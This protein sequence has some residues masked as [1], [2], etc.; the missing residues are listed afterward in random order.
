MKCLICGFDVENSHICPNC[1]QN[2]Y[3]FNKI[4]NI[5]ARLYNDALEKAQ[6]NDFSNAIILIQKSL[7]FNK[8]NTEARNLL[9]L[10]YYQIG[11]LGDAV[12]QWILSSNINTKEDNKAFYYL[13]IFN[14]NIRNFEKLDDAVRLYNQAIKYL[15]NKNDDLAIIRIK[16]ALD[17]NPNF[18]DAIN[19]L[20]FCYILQRKYKQ[21]LKMFQKVLTLDI[22]NKTAINYIDEIQ[23]KK[24]NKKNEIL[25]EQYNYNGMIKTIDEENKEETAQNKTRK[26]VIVSFIIGVIVCGITMYYLFIPGYM[27]KNNKQIEDLTNKIN[28]IKEDTEKIVSEKDGIITSLQQENENTKNQ[29]QSYINIQNNYKKIDEA[30]E[31]YKQGK[32][33]DAKTVIDSVLTDG[34]DETMLKKYN[35]AKAKIK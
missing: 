5:S 29:L 7:Y 6:K 16:K 8:N 3:V 31:L 28:V 17:I 18:I 35:D 4:F 21:A 12:K 30:L 24:K 23:S 26:I 11:R 27:Q 22:H 13:E 15:K 25:T 32:K 1:N 2:I 20:G 9:G 10:L 19:L 14:K 34:F 33:T